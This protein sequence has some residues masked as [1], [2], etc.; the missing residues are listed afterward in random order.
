MSLKKKNVKF[1]VTM[2]VTYDSD[3]ALREAIKAIRD[4]LWYEGM[5]VGESG[6]F[7]ATVKSARLIRETSK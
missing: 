4:G 6:Y 7:H 2:K 1:T 3:V 5:C